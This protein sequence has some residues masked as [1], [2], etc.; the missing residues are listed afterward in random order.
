MLTFLL[1]MEIMMDDD[2]TMLSQEVV[3]I[4]L[5]ELATMVS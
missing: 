5:I 1:K 2:T 4:H 3:V